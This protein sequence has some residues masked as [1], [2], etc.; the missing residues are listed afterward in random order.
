MSTEP[1]SPEHTPEPTAPEPT[2]LGSEAG[3]PKR[4]R[5]WWQ[6]VLRGV[7]FVLGGLVVL[8]LLVLLYLE[9]GSGS[10]L[11]VTQ[12]LNRLNPLF[13]DAHL[14]IGEID[15]GLLRGL[16][17][18]DVN[19][20]DEVDGDTLVHVDT[21]LARYRLAELRKRTLYLDDVTVRG[22]FA[23]MDQQADST[24]DLIRALPV[25]EE[26]TTAA[27]FYIRLDD[28][29]LTGLDVRAQFYE[30]SGRDSVLRAQFPVVV[31]SDLDIGGDLRA[32][33]PLLR[34]S[35]VLP[36]DMLTSEVELS[37]D[38]ADGRLDLD[39]LTFTTPRSQLQGR[40]SVA[41]PTADAP[42]EDLDF[43]FSAQPL[44]FRDLRPI[45]PTLAPGAVMVGR[46]KVTGSGRAIDA[47][48]RF[49]F[50]EGSSDLGAVEFEGSYVAAD[51]DESL[52]YTLGA[53]IDQ[54]SPRL[55]APD[56]GGRVNGRVD[57]AL[58]G[59]DMET[60]SGPIDASLT[61]TR[62]TVAEGETYRVG[63]ANVEARMERGLLRFDVS[64]AAEPNL[65][66]MVRAQGTARPFDET[67]R[68][69]ATLRLATFDLAA[70]NPAATPTDV[71]GTLRVR[72]SGLSGASADLRAGFDLEPSRVGTNELPAG[73]GTIRLVGGRA[74]FDAT[75]QVGEGTVGAI[76]SARF[77]DV[78]HYNIGRGTLENVDVAA[79]TGDTVRSNIDAT[80][81][82]QGRGT[83]PQYL[84]LDATAEIT[85]SYYGAYRVRSADVT[86]EVARGLVTVDAN[87]DLYRGTI[88]VAATARPFDETPTFEVERGRFSNLDLS[89]FTEDESTLTTSLSGAVQVS[90]TGFDPATGAY[91]L[92]L[93][94]GAS[95]VNEQ[96]IEDATARL[97]LRSGRVRGDLSAT[98][99][100]G[101]IALDIDARPLGET[102]TYTISDGSFAGVDVG[103]L[104]A[105]PDLTT[106]LNGTLRAEGVGF[107]PATARLAATVEFSPSQIN[108]ERLSQGRAQIDLADG[109][110]EF[111]TRLDLEEG[112]AEV[113]GEGRFF[114]EVPTY[115]V[116]GSLAGV[117]PA[118][119][120]GNDTLRTG[121]GAQFALEG[122]GLDPATM[123]L[124]GF[125][126]ADTLTYEEVAVSE[127]EARFRLDA[128]V[129]EVDTLNLISNIAYA[130]AGGRVALYDTTRSS[131]FHLKAQVDNLAPIRPLVAA[132]TLA[133]K[134]GY[135]NVRVTG[136]PGELYVDGNSRVEAF[137][138]NDLRVTQ[139]DGRMQGLVEREEDGFAV[140]RADVDATVAYASLPN[141][142]VER[143]RLEGVYEGD[144]LHVEAEM[145]V[146]D[147]RDASFRAN[148][149]LRPESQR[150]VIDD[151]AF[152][153]DGDRWA[154]LQ[155]A[156][157]S[158]AD[159]YRVSN[160][161][162]FS[163][164]Q[165]I[166]IDGAIN[167]QGRQSLLVTLEAVRLDAVADF[168]G[169]PGLGGTTSGY[170]DLTGEAD[171]PILEGQLDLDLTSRGK[172]VGEL[173]LV[174]GYDDL[175]L[176]VDAALS[177][178]T[179][180]TLQAIGSL[181]LDL[182]LAPAIEDG[183]DTGR[184]RL[185]T[186]EADENS[187]VDFTVSSSG[188]DIGWVE[189]FVD[190]ETISEVEGLLTG[191]LGI[192]GTLAEPS[193]SGEAR[194][195]GGRLGLTQLEAVYR[196]LELDIEF[197]DDQ[198]LV[199]H[200]EARSGR[201]SAIVTGTI[202]LTDLTLG[203]FDLD[204]SAENFLA[205]DNREYRIVAGAD[206]ELSG[207]TEAPVLRGG[208]RVQSADIFLVEK[209]AVDA[210]E[211]V[212]LT[213]RDQQTLEQRFGIRLSAADTT[214]FD[215]YEALDLAMNV[216]IVTDTWVRS[217]LSPELDIPFQGDLDVAK[218]AGSLEPRV[219]GS[220][221]VV[222][223]RGRIVQYGR[224]FTID[225]GTLTFNGPPGN[226][227]MDVSAVYA[228]RS[229][230]SGQ[231]EVSI[232]LDLD[233][234]L[235]QLG[236][237]FRSENPSG[238]PLSDILSYIATGR[239]ASQ[240]F[241]GDGLANQGEAF[242]LGQAATVIEGLAEESG[243]GLDVI[244]I[245]PDPR[246]GTLLFTVGKYVTLPIAD[247]SLPPVYTAVSYPIS[248][249][250]GGGGQNDES[251]LQLT[252]E[253]ALLRSLLLSLNRRG[254]D[255]RGTL[256]WERAY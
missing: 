154:L 244:E 138:Y 142:V 126:T 201:G 24:W 229:R 200:I 140:R 46:V 183:E 190:P 147:R 227:T 116:S 12:A 117:D 57:I 210:L 100:E 47:A 129:L 35:I 246:S 60:L 176:R 14:S 42:L 82:L 212:E 130:Q 32:R 84:S 103:A 251:A 3:A 198:V 9:S 48:G 50:S 135:V 221:E 156:T 191:T 19:L 185:Q 104:T 8:V 206:L 133:L 166:A 107:D 234:E 125:V 222:P 30:P 146:D 38:L 112:F 81:T 255:I 65:A 15:S 11:A 93:D 64:A 139:L 204:V 55:F 197:A 18:Y 220:I 122:R 208:V 128:G 196:D 44:A 235:E 101:S 124:D 123:T 88:A 49:N 141:I 68:Y 23:R 216:E 33:V 250:N 194:L 164:D 158:Y 136:L 108:G 111:G 192:A 127:L 223:G 219:F 167:P 87:A 110:A 240:A 232:I 132:E 161:L 256:R 145:L 96:A 174:L 202:D 238:L 40:G 236:I 254:N 253:I 155:P 71:T 245:T 211:T 91:D 150:V 143:T 230:G 179:G 181:P 214:S 21:L 163:D 17:L 13:N 247:H 115:S 205:I 228:V 189:P 175:R 224:R 56:L 83:D 248:Y 131:D 106:D 25:T 187:G 69:D 39:Q 151:F 225:E 76:G 121:I 59:A 159:G 58:D 29:S 172:D 243:L 171:D 73:E 177:H 213:L 153:F 37:G 54:L 95:R 218:A 43:S 252:A 79:L 28:G 134:D 109:F 22:G 26:D 16:R 99:P 207:T 63:R 137:V 178:E 45:A 61:N 27:P 173:A 74:A 193:L 199:Q 144:S 226:P 162:L 4:H 78:L 70:F 62:I 233:G 10:R 51:G 195:V 242:A 20:I 67:P 1:T 169:Y 97:S 152:R 7:G 149:D 215:F 72:G 34:A 168:L 231:E 217:D 52:A 92:R 165:Q 5:P 148:V 186:A 249:R 102:P 31:L 160:L 180:G 53:S 6:R 2:A 182:R 209:N 118:G 119:F 184:V 36:G 203:T 41:L 239:P 77:G 157:V 86:A 188:F 98:L 85:E 80:F 237:T 94:L 170:L 241:Q 89:L 114:D 120:I 105:N 75:V 90:G 113:Q 66:T